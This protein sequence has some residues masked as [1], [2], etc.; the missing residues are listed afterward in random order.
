M[1]ADS[2]HLGINQTDLEER[3]R[4]VQLMADIYSISRMTLVW[5]GESSPDVEGAFETA[6]V[7]RNLFPAA[8]FDTLSP[9]LNAQSFLSYQLEKGNRGQTDNIF[10]LDLISFV[11]LLQRPW[12]KRKWVIQEVVKSDQVVLTNGREK[13]GLDNA[14]RS[15]HLL[16]GL[17]H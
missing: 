2:N 14:W 8:M 7:F 13:H 11:S 5:L 4:Q 16:N 3:G 12:F 1:G 10:Q 6:R 17:V 9:E 15:C